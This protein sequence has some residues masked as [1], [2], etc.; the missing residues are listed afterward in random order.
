MFGDMKTPLRYGKFSF[1]NRTKTRLANL[2]LFLGDDIIRQPK[3][4]VG[5]FVKASAPTGNEPNPEWIFNPWLAMV[6]TG[7][8]VEAWMHIGRSG[9]VMSN[10][11]KHT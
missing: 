1:E 7:N 3:F 11:C 10:A 5:V 9:A 4:H 6:I 2:D 8:L